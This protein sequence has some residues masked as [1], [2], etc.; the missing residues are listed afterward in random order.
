MVVAIGWLN[1]FSIE[2]VFA[3]GWLNIFTWEVLVFTI[4]IHL[5]L[6]GFGTYELPGTLNYQ[7]QT[8]VWLNNHFLAGGFK[9]FLFSS[10]FGEDSHFD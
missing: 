1:I 9:Y 10:L 4:S 5:K 2:M 6:V 7:F 3:I 8:D